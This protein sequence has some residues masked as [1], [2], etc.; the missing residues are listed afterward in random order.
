MNN[1]TVKTG[2]FAEEQTDVIAIGVLEKRI[3][4]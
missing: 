3:D 4:F 2:G 1:I